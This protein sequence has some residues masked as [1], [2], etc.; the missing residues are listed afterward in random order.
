MT[1]LLRTLPLLAALFIASA[2]SAAPE[3]ERAEKALRAMHAVLV[4]RDYD[5]FYREHCHQHI[6]K[7]LTLGR[8]KREMATERGKTLHELFDAVIGALDEQAGEDVLVARVQDDPGEYEFNL[9]KRR[10]ADAPLDIDER[11]L[12]RIELKKEGGRWKFMDMD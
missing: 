10:D 6:K 4:Q 11:Q 3:D 5:T 7:Q 1:A 2:A 8:M 9:V 12:W